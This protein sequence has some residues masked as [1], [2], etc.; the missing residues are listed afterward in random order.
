MGEYAYE[1]LCAID[2]MAATGPEAT[3]YL[4]ADFNGFAADFERAGAGTAQ[5]FSES[6]IVH[7][8]HTA[9][10]G[11]DSLALERTDYARIAFVDYGGP[12]AYPSYLR[13]T[14]RAKSDRIAFALQNAPGLA[15]G[16]L[17]IGRF[18]GD[19]RASRSRS[20]MLLVR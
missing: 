2:G 7:P 10:V 19:L 9:I 18:V 11:G 6:L 16:I 4:L 13:E 1:A 15:G 8:Y 3:F 12:K 17:T 14:P 20:G 5:K